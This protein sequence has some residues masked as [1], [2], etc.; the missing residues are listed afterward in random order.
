MTTNTTSTTLAAGAK[1]VLEITTEWPTELDEIFGRYLL[2]WDAL[3][4]AFGP[5]VADADYAPLRELVSEEA[6]EDLLE[7]AAELREKDQYVVLPE[8]TI[9]E[10]QVRLPNPVP[11]DKTEGNEV[12]I[13]DCWV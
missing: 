12:I 13:Q 10:H 8:N 3:Y 6:Y 9:T 5:P 4:I 7:Q 2:Y 1:P 11:L